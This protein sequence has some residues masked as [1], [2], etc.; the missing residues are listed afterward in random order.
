M[1]TEER[2]GGGLSEHQMPALKQAYRLLGRQTLFLGF[3][4]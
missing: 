1:V 3:L 4:R 2:T